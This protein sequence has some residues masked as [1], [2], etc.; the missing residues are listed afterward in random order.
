MF[1]KTPLGGGRRLRRP[2]SMIA[3][4]SKRG[5]GC[6]D[7]YKV[8]RSSLDR[9]PF[10]SRSHPRDWCLLDAHRAQAQ[11][12][13][14]Q[15]E[16]LVQVGK[17]TFASQGLFNYDF[18]FASALLECLVMPLQDKLDDW[19]KNVAQLDKDHA[20]EYKKLRTE[21]KKKTGEE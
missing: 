12:H 11:I 4:G 14:V 20:K 15:N 16:D 6:Y 17:R 2:L 8:P 13:G 5:E 21:I 19:R 3:R 1:I 7:D 18:L 9:V 10:F